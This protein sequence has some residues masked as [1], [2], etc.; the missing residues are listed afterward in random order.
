MQTVLVLALLFALLVG[1]VVTF[2]AH[3]NGTHTGVGPLV[4]LVSLL[5]LGA[6]V[7][8]RRRPPSDG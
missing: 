3:A 1:G 8:P 5:G 7:G 6:L 4:G 2:E